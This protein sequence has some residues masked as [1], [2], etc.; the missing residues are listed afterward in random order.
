MLSGGANL[1]GS[2]TSPE[3]L[4]KLAPGESIRVL[5]RAALQQ[6]SSLEGTGEGVFV[7]HAVLDEEIVKTSNG[8]TFEDTQEVGSATSGEYT[9][10]SL[11]KV[12]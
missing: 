1:Y 2:R 6:A 9:L 10:Q 8:E 5:T 7:G 3:T 4:V 12:R 11:S